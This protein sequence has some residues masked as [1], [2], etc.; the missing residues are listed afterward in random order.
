MGKKAREDRQAGSGQTST[1][2][3]RCPVCGETFD[4]RQELLNHEQTHC[5]EQVGA[6]G[7]SDEAVEE[8]AGMPTEG[9]KPLPFA[10]PRR[11]W[12]TGEGD[13][14]EGEITGRQTPGGR[15]PGFSGDA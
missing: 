3:Y 12:T 14:E 6:T 15:N 8:D 1:S 10:G 9:E 4:T 7:T 13:R 11:K 5:G 2:P